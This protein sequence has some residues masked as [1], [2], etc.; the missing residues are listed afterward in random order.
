[1]RENRRLEGNEPAS[2]RCDA[3]VSNP[4]EGNAGKRATVSEGMLH[5]SLLR[6]GKQS[7]GGHTEPRRKACSLTSSAVPESGERERV[8]RK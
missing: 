7:L 4:P 5:L 1:M 3:T 8:R 6:E 2:G